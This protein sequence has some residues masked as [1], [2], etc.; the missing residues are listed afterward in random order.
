MTDILVVGAG[1]A[2]LTAA[3]TLMRAGKRVRVLEASGRVGGRV[4]SRTHDGFLLD[5]GYQVLFTG[6]P[7]V[8]RQLDLGALDLVALPPAAAVRTGARVSV[9]GDPFRDPG[10]LLSSLASRALSLPD[11]LR[12]ARLGAELRVG[13]AHH[14]LVGP[15]ESTHSYLTRQGFSA[16]ALTN[17]FG[18]FFGGI[19]LKRDLSTSA[20]L[21]RY[22]FRMLMDGDIALPRAGMGQVAAQLAHDLPISLNVRVSRLQATERGVSV[23]TSLGELE[24][25]QVIVATDPPAAAKLL[26]EA[27]PALESVSSTYVYYASSEPLDAQPRLLL[28]AEAGVINNAHW[29]SNV[30]PERAAPGRHLLVATLLGTP[31]SEDAALDVQV[32]GELQRWYGDA[33]KELHLLGTERI[34]HAQF[35]QPPGYVAQLPGHTTGIPGVLRASEITSMSGIQGALESGEKAAAIVLNDT[36]GMSR[37]RGA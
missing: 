31:P 30:M 5:A 4:Q 19:F 26:D 20:R 28:N 1:L 13:P 37:P 3:R 2:G 16:A 29:L 8:K 27:A 17:F 24:A 9:L 18:P 14:L 15:D 10:S 35:A 23:V 7:A 36:A 32:R 22:Y 11:K 12:V 21:F 25:E 6:Y 34:A 33:V